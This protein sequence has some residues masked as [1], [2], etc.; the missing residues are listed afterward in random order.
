M[1]KMPA[2]VDNVCGNGFMVFMR[3]VS[4]SKVNVKEEKKHHLMCFSQKQ[5]LNGG[6]FSN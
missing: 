1:V 5:N 2:C 4:D 6:S 3:S